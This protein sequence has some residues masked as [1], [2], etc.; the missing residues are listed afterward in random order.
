MNQGAP[1]VLC[2]EDDRDTQDMLRMLLQQRGYKV[3][4]T[5]NC[6]DALRLLRENNI[7]LVLMD[8][9][10]SDGNGIELCA[11]VREFNKQLPIIFL[12]GS[13]YENA[14]ESALKS[15]ANA[16]LTKPVVLKELFD[17]LDNYAPLP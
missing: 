14:H 1:V 12:S 17:A 15:G 9:L 4:T 7:A 8:N 13:V 5:D 2:V 6:G 10:L 11:Q 3:K 16:F